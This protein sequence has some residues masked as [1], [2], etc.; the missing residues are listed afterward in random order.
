M[1]KFI[2][3]FDIRPGKDPDEVFKYWSEK[4][5]LWVKDKMPEAKGY[6]INRVTS[7]SNEVDYFGVVEIWFDDMESALKAVGRLQSAPPDYF[8]TELIQTPRRAF[9][10]EKEIIKLR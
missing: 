9:V 8:L 3:I 6:V 1:V 7:A 2:S 4:H 5:T 10:E